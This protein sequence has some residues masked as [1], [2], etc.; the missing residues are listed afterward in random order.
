MAFE[1][2]RVVGNSLEVSVLRAAKDGRLRDPANEAVVGPY[3]AP[4]GEPWDWWNGYLYSSWQLLDLH[5]I[6][7]LRD[8][9]AVGSGRAE[10]YDDR[11]RRFQARTRALIALSSHFL[12]GIIGQFSQP[13]GVVQTEYWDFWHGASVI[14]LLETAGFDLTDLAGE[15]QHL[16]IDADWRDPLAD[17][18]PLIRHSNH[19]GWFKLKGTALHS[20]WLRIGAEV[21]LQAHEELSE[22]G[23]L[24]PLPGYGLNQQRLRPPA[25]ERD[26]LDEA[27]GRLGLSPHPR[28]LLLLEGETEYDHIPKLLAVLGIDGSD[29]VRVQL[30]NS[31][32]INATLITRY[33]V[34]PRLGK[35]L[36]D[37]QLLD[38]HPT[39]LI[40]AVDPDPRWETQQKRDA[41]RLTLQ[42][43]IRTEI[44]LQNGEIGPEDLDFLVK[45]RVW[46][47]DKYEL[48]NFTDDELVPV[49]T[50]I[51]EI[52]DN[53]KRSEPT[54]EEQLR[55]QL[56]DAR[57]RHADIKVALR[58][59]GMREDKVLL[60]EMLRGV[61]VENFKDEL[62]TSR[63]LTKPVYELVLEVY[64][65]VA[66]LSGPGYALQKVDPS[67]QSAVDEP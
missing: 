18:L 64:R 44:R 59:M 38:R 39:A 28:V 50:R 55:A 24:E 53:P 2:A 37:V 31:T 12:P 14:S 23:V 5:R 62:K 46:G 45:V 7:S 9:M 15:G 41:E 49:L 29:L 63:A 16:L 33:G 54:W 67:T 3:D 8:W 6:P 19:S 58:K 20:I 22:A 13:P 42:N 52:R 34:A 47:E 48:A 66:R 25:A 10:L 32:H 36:G 40:I 26:S 51:A 27:L 1:P 56:Q 43:A 11:S 21:L 30:C 61:L 35:K 65:T 57:D 4:A 17:W 60:A